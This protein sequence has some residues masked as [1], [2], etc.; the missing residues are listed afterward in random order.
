MHRYSISD[1][2]LGGVYLTL[3]I[4]RE[5]SVSEEGQQA[6]NEA[7][8]RALGLVVIRFAGLLH[9]LETSTIEL[10]GLGPDY[11]RNL[12]LGAALADRTATPIVSA[13]IS[14][15]V[16]RWEGQMT[17]DDFEIVKCLRRELDEVVR[18]R[19]RLMHDAWMYKTGGEQSHPLSLHR[20]RAHGKGANYESV[21]YPPAKLEE[22]SERLE[23]LASVVNGA[24]WYCRPG[25]VGPELH[26]RMR[27][28][29]GR[30]VR[31]NQE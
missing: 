2:H 21:D 22:L 30:V 1:R 8:Y 5:L 19:N 16:K 6:I 17:P 20:V 14:V 15:F 10:F 3:G 27:V 29:D 13:Y 26:M 7:T 18:E 9:S 12:L 25:Q 4:E 23:R 24:V 11:K 28:V 31:I